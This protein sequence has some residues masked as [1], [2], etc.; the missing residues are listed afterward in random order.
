MQDRER[1]ERERESA[2][3]AE[4]PLWNEMTGVKRRKDFSCTIKIYYI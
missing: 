2:R 1:D 4:L 3:P